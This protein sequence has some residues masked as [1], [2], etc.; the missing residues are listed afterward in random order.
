MRTILITAAAS[1]AMLA[2]SA[3]AVA[4]APRAACMEDA[5]CWSWST[6][7]NRS[8]AVTT[9]RGQRII[10]GPC[11]FRRLAEAD[12]IRYKPLRGDYWAIT[13]GCGRSC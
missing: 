12:L 9:L 4:H 11:Y 5:A 8:R 2:S 1:L 7:G 6:M 10:V 13:H 3:P